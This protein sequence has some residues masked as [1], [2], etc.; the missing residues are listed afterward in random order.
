MTQVSSS[1]T[2]YRCP[3][4]TRRKKSWASPP[5][6]T[7]KTAS[8]LMS[9]TNRSPRYA[10]R[11]LQSCSHHTLL[12]S[13][14]G[15]PPPLSPGP[16]AVLGLVGAGLRHVRQAEPH[17]VPERHRRGDAL[18]PDH[19]HQNRVAGHSGQFQ[20]RSFL[21]IFISRSFSFDPSAFD[22][23][24][25]QAGIGN[26]RRL[27]KDLGGANKSSDGDNDAWSSRLRRLKH[28]TMI[29]PTFR[30]KSTS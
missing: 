2:F 22:Q 15:P 11:I 24:E 7:G 25:T 17:G 9:T 3:S 18:V 16:D 1:R 28:Q 6:S 4:S 12:S 20:P 14:T 21:H 8:R 26:I 29:S 19:V 30:C 27:Y 13:L 5:S 10:A 23:E